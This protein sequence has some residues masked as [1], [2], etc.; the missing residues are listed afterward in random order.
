M[1]DSHHINDH[2]EKHVDGENYGYHHSRRHYKDKGFEFK[3]YRRTFYYADPGHNKEKLFEQIKDKEIREEARQ[4]DECSRSAFH[5]I[6]NSSCGIKSSIQDSFKSF[7]SDFGV[8]NKVRRL[9][10]KIKDTLSTGLKKAPWSNSI[11]P[12]PKKVVV[13]MKMDTQDLED[14]VNDGYSSPSTQEEQHHQ[15]ESHHTPSSSSTQESRN[16]AP[17]AQEQMHD[18][19]TAQEPKAVAP[20]APGTTMQSNDLSEEDLEAIE[21]DKEMLRMKHPNIPPPPSDI[22]YASEKVHDVWSDGIVEK[23]GEQFTKIAEDNKR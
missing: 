3:T 14:I 23:W 6:S 12:K 2:Y 21:R 9:Y 18:T 17:P 15:E 20:S 4:W 5:R 7:F 16:V 13:M 19:L 10:D 11:R 1:P 22:K 8:E